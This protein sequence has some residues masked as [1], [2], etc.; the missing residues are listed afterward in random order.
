MKH[1]EFI[2]GKTK[3]YPA[4]YA[5]CLWRQIGTKCGPDLVSILAILTGGGGGGA[6]G[7]VSRATPGHPMGAALPTAVTP[8]EVVL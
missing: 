6:G 3:I 1:F 4:P 7:F 2:H 8:L 5:K